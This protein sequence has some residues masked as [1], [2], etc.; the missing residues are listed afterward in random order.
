MET[1]ETHLCFARCGSV[2]ELAMLNFS[3]S[4]DEVFHTCVDNAA[5]LNRLF[6]WK[7]NFAAG[8]SRVVAVTELL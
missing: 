3:A 8:I 7:T 5:F 2:F 4:F 6:D 1:L